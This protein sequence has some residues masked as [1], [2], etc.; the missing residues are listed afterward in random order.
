LQKFR[1]AEDKYFDKPFRIFNLDEGNELNRQ[2]WKDFE[3]RTFFQRLRR[4]RYN[5]RLKGICIP[6]LGE[7]V[8]NIILSRMNFIFEVENRNE[9]TTATL[10][11]GTYYFY[12]IPRGNHIYS[13]YYKKNLTREDIKK[14][15]FANVKDKEYLKGMPR[16]IVVKKCNCNGVWGFKEKEYIQ[17][18]KMTNRSFTVSKGIQTSLI[19]C[20]YMYKSNITM[21]KLGLKRDDIR[22]HSVF[23]VINRINK[24]FEEDPDILTKY[25]NL[26]KRK[27]DERDNEEIKDDEEYAPSAAETDILEDVKS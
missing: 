27:L 4:E 1:E 10:N 9:L 2:D 11:K 6:V 14:V 25:E 24:I 3:V 15:L 23:K 26:Y 16:N 18:L 17:E 21:K 12:I 13:P 8:V 5:R 20:F 7:M 22:Y 19:E